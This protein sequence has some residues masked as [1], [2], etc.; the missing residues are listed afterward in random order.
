MIYTADPLGV[1]EEGVDLR[2]Q[3][4]RQVEG[5]LFMVLKMTTTTIAMSTGMRIKLVWMMK[6]R[7]MFYL[8][9]QNPR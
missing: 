5:L 3:L 6:K 2:E 1:I 4:A 8:R 9:F 7:Y